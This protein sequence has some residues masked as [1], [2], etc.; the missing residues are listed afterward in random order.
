MSFLEPDPYLQINAVLSAIVFTPP[1]S[2]AIT[3]VLVILILLLGSALI[4]GSEVAYFSLSPHDLSILKNQEDKSSV[5]IQSLLSRPEK[6][7]ATILIT[8]NFI[9]VGIV[10]ISTYVTSAI[11]DFSEE[12]V[13][14]FVLQI[15]AVTFLILL[16]G[17]I[18][19]K[20][21]ANQYSLRFAR[22]MSF[23]IIIL[24]VLFAPLSIL[25]IR[26]TSFAKRKLLIRHSDLSMG[27]LSYALDLTSGVIPEEKNILKSIVKFSD[28][29]VV[30]IM[31]PRMDVIAVEKSRKLP[32]IIE[33]IN[34]SG[35][36]RIPVYVETLDNVIGILY[37]KDLLAHVDKGEEYN[38]HS[39]IRPCYFVP[40]TKKINDLLQEFREKKIHLAIVVDEYGGTEGIVTLE[41]VLEEI[42]GEITDESDDIE[43][44]YV[45]MDENN[46]VF[47]AKILLNDF[48]KILNI[49]SDIFQDIRGD[50]DTLAG[51]ILEIKGEIPGVDEKL[52]TDGF[53]FTIVSSDKRRIKKIKVTISGSMKEDNEIAHE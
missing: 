15:V 43:P 18:V 5:R 25:L 24:E 6:L 13:F 36:S 22:L 9:N 17:E 35:Y 29:E 1:S 42:V 44:L 23:P 40:E 8:N 39:L 16:F 31:K 21:F 53:T 50:A 45:K 3:G 19:P 41:D 51:L 37:A 38:W 14:A 33:I 20:L 30:D 27:D 2:G 12:P 26:S 7:L 52:N 4:S 10:I 46:Y 28:I 47:D 34:N 32:D 11:I 48:Y 49:N